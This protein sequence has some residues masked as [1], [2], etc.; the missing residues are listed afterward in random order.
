MCALTLK[1]LVSEFNDKVSPVYCA[2]L[3]ALKA[4][5]RVNYSL[6]FRNL[7]EKG[8]NLNVVRV[9]HF[10]YSNQSMIVKLETAF[11]NLLE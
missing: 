9:L 3:D 11:H 5:D 8:I 10:W 6:L 7:I 1:Q 2:F 4:F